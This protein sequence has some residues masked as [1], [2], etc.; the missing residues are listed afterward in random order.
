MSSSAPYTPE[1]L[2]LVQGL[3]SQMAASVRNA[4]LHEE[5]RRLSA[6]EAAA[7]AAAAEREYAARVL[8]AVGDGIAGV[9]RD[10]VIRLWDPAGGKEPVPLAG[11]KR[12]VVVAF[13]PNGRRLASASRD[14]I[15]VRRQGI[16][17]SGRLLGSLRQFSV[18]GGVL[19]RCR[20]LRLREHNRQR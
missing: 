9:D 20:G 6:A 8:E 7:R 10:G 13:S 3:V 16:R 19:A 12:E 5:R 1:H 18:D 11:H 4:R 17:A 2:E 14:G 15:R